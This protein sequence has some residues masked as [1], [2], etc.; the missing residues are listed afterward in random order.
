ME[1]VR[2]DDFPKTHVGTILTDSFGQSPLSS[3]LAHLVAGLTRYV[4]EVVRAVRIVPTCGSTNY[5][6]GSADQ[7]HFIFEIIVGF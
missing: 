1:K 5:F 2:T 7:T 3:S 4:T 6:K